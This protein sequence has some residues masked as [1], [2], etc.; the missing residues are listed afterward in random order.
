[1]YSPNITAFEYSAYIA[2]IPQVSD[3]LVIASF[4]VVHG[5]E[6][7]NKTNSGKNSV[8]FSDLISLNFTHSKKYG[9]IFPNVILS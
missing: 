4:A 3:Q 7:F 8:S 6:C 5:H 9:K 2:H 1:M